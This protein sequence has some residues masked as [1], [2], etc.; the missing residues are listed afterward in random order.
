M[1]IL[2]VILKLMAERCKTKRVYNGGLNISFLKILME[3]QTPHMEVD[4]II[5]S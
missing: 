3:S 4:R 1:F 5:T 2:I